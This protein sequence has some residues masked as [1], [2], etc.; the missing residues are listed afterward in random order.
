MISFEKVDLHQ[1]GN[2]SMFQFMYEE[3]KSSLCIDKF[4]VQMDDYLLREAFERKEQNNLYNIDQILYLHNGSIILAFAVI[5]SNTSKVIVL[6]ILCSNSTNKNKFNGK[7]LGVYLLDNIYETYNKTHIIKIHPANE[8]VKEYYLKWKNP[9]LKD[10]TY[11]E[12]GKY[13]IYGDLQNID[14][15]NWRD[16]FMSNYNGLRFI[17]KYIASE[18]VGENPAQKKDFLL[19]KIN[20][21]TILSESNKSQAIQVVEST[22]MYDINDVKNFIRDNM[23]EPA[24][25]GKRRRKS[26]KNKRKQS[27]KSK[28]P[29]RRKSIKNT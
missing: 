22:V 11:Y 2:L 24:G 12:T 6:D 29:K 21:S 17:E 3:S 15:S 8:N 14:E 1:H 28:S 4:G 10:E 18:I 27:R 20:S 7:Y 19:E 23:N 26:L 9:A 25:G 16:I 5:Y 13:L